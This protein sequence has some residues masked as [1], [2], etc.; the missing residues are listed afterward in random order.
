M[1]QDAMKVINDYREAIRANY[2][3]E[4]ADKSYFDYG[5]GWFNFQMA[6]RFPDGSCGIITGLGGY[7]AFRRKDIVIRTNELRRR[8]AQKEDEG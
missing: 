4:I 8:V 6:R 5:K 3:D 7:D 1:K 2:G